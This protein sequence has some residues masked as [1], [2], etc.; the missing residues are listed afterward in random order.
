MASPWGIKSKQNFKSGYTF[1]VRHA[2]GAAIGHPG[3]GEHLPEYGP[4]Q[5]DK[6]ISCVVCCFVRWLLRWGE[7][8]ILKIKREVSSDPLQV[9]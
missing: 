1:A 5:K 7:R 8:E 6:N 4:K 9:G 2:E 3:V